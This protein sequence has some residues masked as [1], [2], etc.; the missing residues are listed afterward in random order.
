MHVANGNLIIEPKGKI[1]KFAAIKHRMR[2]PLSCVKSVSTVL[3]PRSKI[4]RSVRVVGTALPPHFAGRF[5]SFGNGLIFC[6]L[7]NREK[8]VTLKLHDFTYREVVV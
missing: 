4:Y 5:Y 6:M 2:I 8:C 3:V 7:S 1:S